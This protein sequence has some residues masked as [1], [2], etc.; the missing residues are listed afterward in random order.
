LNTF[1][2]KLSF[3]TENIEFP[4]IEMMQ[5]HRQQQASVGQMPFHFWHMLK[6]FELF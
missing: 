4:K 2:P 3:A 6:M 5:E 1:S